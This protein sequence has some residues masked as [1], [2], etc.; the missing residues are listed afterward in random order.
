MCK[1]MLWSVVI[2]RTKLRGFASPTYQQ[3]RTV[4]YI[5]M[6]INTV[7]VLHQG[8]H[9]QDRLAHQHLT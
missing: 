1:M 9:F 2:Y 6:S 8:K 5:R 3:L 4:E 7:K